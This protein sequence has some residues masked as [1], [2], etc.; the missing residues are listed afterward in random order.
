M[1][2][3]YIITHPG[4]CA[5]FDRVVTPLRDGSPVEYCNGLLHALTQSVAFG[6]HCPVQQSVIAFVLDVKQVCLQSWNAFWS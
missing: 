2:Q 4:L 3:F 6:G 1:I 5:V